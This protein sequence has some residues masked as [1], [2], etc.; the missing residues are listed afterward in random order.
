MRERARHTL[1]FK[2][3]LEAVSIVSVDS[4]IH[5]Y[6]EDIQAI[7]LFDNGVFV[8]RFM[9][10][11]VRPCVAKQPGAKVVKHYKFERRAFPNSKYQQLTL[12]L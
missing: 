1:V 12:S 4:V 5:Y 3:V 9:T 2:D 8:C 6:G 10:T 11:F 7:E